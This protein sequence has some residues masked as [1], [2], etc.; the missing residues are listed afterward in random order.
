MTNIYEVLRRPIE[1]EKSRYQGIKLHQYVFE[2]AGDATKAQI[3]QAVQDLFDV[4]VIR[5]NV[6][7]SAKR[8]RR[9]KTRRVVVRK[10]AYKKAMVTIRADQSIDTLGFGGV[11]G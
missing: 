1:T 3:K 5:V 10:P 2:V 7:V 9:G 4:D 11:Q 8:G 6:V